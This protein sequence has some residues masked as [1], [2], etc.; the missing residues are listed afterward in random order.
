MNGSTKS[1][2]NPA[3]TKDLNN[4][5]LLCLICNI[6][7]KSKLWIAHS[8]GRKHRENVIRFKNQYL[9]TTQE[10]SSTKRHLQ[11][12]STSTATPV[13]KLKVAEVKT[14]LVDDTSENAPWERSSESKAAGTS[15]FI[16]KKNV[17]EGVPEGFFEDEKLNNRVVDTIEKRANIEQEYAHFMKELD[18]AK[19]EEEQREENEEHFVAIEHDIELIDEQID[20]WKRVNQLELRRDQLYSTSVETVGKHREEILEEMSDDDSDVDLAGWRSKGI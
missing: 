15:K 2:I 6:Q 7:V 18:E 4:G 16:Q 12:P 10:T 13:K 19:Q 9:A 1:K 17:I 11:E 20:H 5:N 8:N 3:I 14:P